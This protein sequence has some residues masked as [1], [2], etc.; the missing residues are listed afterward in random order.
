L[1]VTQA[2]LQAQFELKLAI[3]ERLS[4]TH[5]AINQIR[6]VREQV[7][8]WLKR[9]ADSAAIKEA[10]RLLKEELKAVEGELINLDFEKPRP[11]LNRIKEKWDA[12]SSMIDESDHAPTAGAQEFYAELKTQLDAQRRKLKRLID[13]QVKAFSDLIQKEGVPPI[14]I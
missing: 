11:G 3:R 5:T 1:P 12:L 14:A 4:E 10:A 8:E 13:G 9:A 2:D 6:R 7:E